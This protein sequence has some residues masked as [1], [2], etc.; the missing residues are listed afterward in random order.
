[1]Q[2]M[3]WE[4]MDCIDYKR[5]G[6]LLIVAVIGEKFPYPFERISSIGLPILQ[7]F[8]GCHILK[9]QFLIWLSKSVRWFYG[10]DSAFRAN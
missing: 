9:L 10:N 5:V 4:N 2:N 7:A 3:V 1:M 6:I 8:H